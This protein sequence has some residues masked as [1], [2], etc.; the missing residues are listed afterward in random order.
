MVTHKSVKYGIRVRH[1]LSI[2]VFGGVNMGR[3]LGLLRPLEHLL[4]SADAVAAIM[5]G[6]S[7]ASRAA[8]FHVEMAV[9]PVSRYCGSSQRSGGAVLSGW[10]YSMAVPLYRA[11]PHRLPALITLHPSK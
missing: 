7:C 9:V 2:G 10:A 6:L 5:G 11:E 1:P 3:L 8:E 4:P